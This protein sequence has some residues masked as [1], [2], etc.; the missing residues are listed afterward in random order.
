MSNTF[1]VAAGEFDDCPD[2]ADVY[3]VLGGKGKRCRCDRSIK[4]HEPF[5]GGDFPT[6]FE[7]CWYCHAEII[8]SGSRWSTY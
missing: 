1:T 3:G 7:I 8:H 6:P 5:F 4:V 2:C